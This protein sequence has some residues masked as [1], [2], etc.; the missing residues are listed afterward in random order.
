MSFSVNRQRSLWWGLSL[1]V[2]LS[3]LVAM[4]IS[5]VS[6]G[7]PLRLGLDFIGGTRLQ[8][9]LACSA[10]HNC[11]QP[12][13]IDVVRQVLNQQGLG[14][15]SLQIVGEYGVSIRTVPLSVDQRTRLSDALRQKIGDFDPQ[16]TQIETVGPTLGKEILRSGL[17]A[18]LVSFIGITIYLTLRFQFDYACFA[19]VALVHD[20]LVTTGIFAI[21]ALV[22]GVEIDSLFIVALLT[23]IGFSVNDTVVIYDRVRETL[24]LNPELGIQEVVD[25]AVVQTLGRS[26]NTTL[27]TLLP[28]ITI[29]LFGGDTLRY[30]A[31]ALL[32]GFTT[33][34][35]SSIFIASTLLAWW[36]DRPPPRPAT[37][38][39][40]TTSTP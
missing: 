40:E 27:T 11:S 5:W 6:L 37:N 16:K 23:I 33:G 15:S 25:Q 34:A 20:V 24:K 10:T 18:L 14:N 36:R 8:F 26:I 12:I 4:A 29:L 21:L 30:F 2:I 13:D 28:L 3:G 38:T 9:E 7:S 31:L 32:I 19:L 17:L 1:V 39:L 22:A 35:Y